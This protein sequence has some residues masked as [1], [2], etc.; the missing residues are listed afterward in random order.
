MHHHMNK[1]PK[2]K[3]KRTMAQKA[4]DAAFFE[5]HHIRG[6]SCR[7][8]A[9]MI[10]EIRPYTLS[11][12][13][14]NADLKKLGNQWKQA[15]LTERTAAVAKELAGLQAQEDELWKAWERSKLDRESRTVETDKV[16]ISDSQF[17]GITKQKTTTE[18]QSGEAAYMRL[19]LEI[20]DQRRHLLGLDAETII[21]DSRDPKA[22]IS[23]SGQP[24]AP[25]VHLIM[26]AGRAA[27]IMDTEPPAITPPEPKKD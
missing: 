16:K 5:H 8:L 2:K 12:S 17:K 1:D 6:K 23:I 27:G 15:A 18:G 26:P 10:G 21:R 3:N 7:E 13:Q 9:K 22:A 4:A 25:I 11:W 19:I 20:R 24:S 14:V